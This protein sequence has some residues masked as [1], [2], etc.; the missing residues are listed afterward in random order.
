MALTRPLAI[1]TRLR[2]P[3]EATLPPRAWAVRSGAKLRRGC[4]NLVANG[5]LEDLGK[6]HAR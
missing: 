3:W 4:S 6:R 1:P 2:L 5:V